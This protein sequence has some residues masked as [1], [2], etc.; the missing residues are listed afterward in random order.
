MGRGCGVVLELWMSTSDQMSPFQEGSH[1]ALICDILYR[2]E[3]SGWGVR[4][5]A[6]R[7]SLLDSASLNTAAGLERADGGAES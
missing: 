2:C 7:L 5:V 3:G 6:G 1:S 4:S